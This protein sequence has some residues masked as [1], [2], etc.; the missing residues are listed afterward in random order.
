MLAAADAQF[1]ELLICWGGQNGDVLI[2]PFCF[3][4][5]SGIIL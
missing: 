5:L 2:L 3:Y 1:M 4:L